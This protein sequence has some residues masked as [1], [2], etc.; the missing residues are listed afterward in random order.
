MLN[1]RPRERITI[2][3]IKSHPFFNE[4]D[5]D[6]LAERKQEPPIMLIMDEL[7]E[8]QATIDQFNAQTEEEQFL[9]KMKGE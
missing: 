8:S 6:K 2:D 3:Q 4:I 9:S 5:W 7:N 1:K